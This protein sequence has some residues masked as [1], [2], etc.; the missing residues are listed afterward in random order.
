MLV[1]F[2]IQRYIEDHFHRR[3]LE[4]IDQ[5]AVKLANAYARARPTSDDPQLLSSFARIRTIF[6]RNNTSLNRR[7]FEKKLLS[8]LDQN[9]KKKLTAQYLPSRAG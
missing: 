2:S 8:L 1:V 4:D 5:Y 6:Y 3:G 9:F 7:A